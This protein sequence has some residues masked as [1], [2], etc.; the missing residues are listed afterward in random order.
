MRDENKKGN[1]GMKIGMSTS[2]H[3]R[4]LRRPEVYFSC[5]QALVACAQGGF[6]VINLDFI[7]YS[8]PGQPMREDNW[9][10]WCR[11]QREIA[12]RLGLLVTYAHAPFYD[13]KLDQPD[14]DPLYEELIRRSIRG[15]G[16]MGSKQ[17]VF[18]PGSLND[19]TWYNQ[20]L[21]LERN[22]R[23][24]RKYGELCAKEGVLPCMENM[25]EPAHGRRFGSSVE[26][27]LELREI[28]G[29]G[30]GVCW[31]FGHAH[32]AGIDQCNALREIGSRLTM[33]HLN[34][35]FGRLDDHLAPCFGTIQW[36]PIM[37]TLKEIGFNG[38]LVF[39]NFTFFDGLPERLRVPAMKLCYDV[40]VYL[41]DL[42][43]ESN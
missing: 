19:G 23:F 32:M 28:L 38:D 18:H 15:A 5:E 25:M 34:D 33:L 29:D 36:T 41:R 9:E 21:S 14:G 12:D 35:N 42:M 3:G 4:L 37:K 2:S 16:I 13:W 7:E 40:G 24:Y 22:V 30:Y 1:T 17:I 31:D 10:D 26:E 39:E 6:E 27:L 11:Q 8:K 20:K 43:E